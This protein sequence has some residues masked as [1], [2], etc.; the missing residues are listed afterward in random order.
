MNPTLSFRAA[1][2]NDAEA[3]A[4]LVRAAYSKWIPVIGREPKPM[5]VDYR[6]AVAANDIALLFDQDVLVG[7]IETIRKDDCI[8]IE[9]VAVAPDHQGKRLGQRLLAHAEDLAKAARHTEVRLLTNADFKA[10]VSLY[11]KLGY[12]ITHTEPFMGGTTVHMAKRL[13]SPASPGVTLTLKELTGDYAIARLQN[14]AA[15]PG[16]A[17]GA[18]FVSVTRTDDELSVVCLR[19]RIPSDVQ[20]DDGWTAFKFVGPFAFDQTGIVLSV[21]R[22]LSTSGIGIFVVSTF[23]GDHLLLKQSDVDRARA[24]LRHAGHSFA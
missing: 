17:D 10:N 20:S 22:P 12:A 15:I 23:D 16:W 14:D 5:T 11:Q 4:C 13:N 18:G 6:L 21:V 3:I 1:S 9:N 24:L 7:L 2:S 19:E 8:W